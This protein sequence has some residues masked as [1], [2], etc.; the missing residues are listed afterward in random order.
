MPHASADE[1]PYA[2]DAVLP[3]VRQAANVIRDL[4][5]ARLKEMDEYRAD[6]E[7]S[8]TFYIPVIT[9]TQFLYL[10]GYSGQA[11]LLVD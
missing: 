6:I 4:A 3:A 9:Q 11:S 7:L 2:D 8:Q 10:T 1:G 5:D